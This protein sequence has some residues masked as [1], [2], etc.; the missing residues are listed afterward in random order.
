[1][2]VKQRLREWA[3][4][5]LEPR[6]SPPTQGHPLERIREEQEN[7][8]AGTGGFHYDTIDGV[9]CMPDGGLG[10]MVDRMY[11]AITHDQRCREIDR[12]VAEMRQRYRDYW[13]VVDVTYSGTHPRDVLKGPA[14]A[15]RILGIARAEYG[16]R[17]QAVYGWLEAR[18]GMRK[19]A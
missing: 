11:W 8:G 10:D 18:L 4:W 19:A 9:A 16:T 6:F 3:L 12:L 1:M 7:A 15:S 2:R 14:V 13:N 5:R 17:M